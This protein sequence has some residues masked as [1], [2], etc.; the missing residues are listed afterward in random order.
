[1]SPTLALVFGA[2]DNSGNY[3]PASPN[4]GSYSNVWLDDVRFY[5]AFLSD[6]EVAS[7]YG[8]GLG[9]VGQNHGSRSTVQ[10][11]QPLPPEW[12]LLTKL[13]PPI[14]R[15]VIPWLTLPVG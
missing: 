4:M 2:K 9:D 8:G 7:I 3:N 12:P 14:T 6:T 15:P 5:N 10:R 13:L 11:L 1:M